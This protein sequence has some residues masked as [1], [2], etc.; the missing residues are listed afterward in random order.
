MNKKTIGY[1]LTGV[2]SVSLSAS[3]LPKYPSE[4]YKVNEIETEEELGKFY[5]YYNKGITYTATIVFALII[6]LSLSVLFLEKDSVVIDILLFVF[7]FV[8]IF[9][10]SISIKYNK[11]L[12][13]NKLMIY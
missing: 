8:E 7:I 9:R 10:F 13:D 2:G 4:F 12:R 3:K 1:F 6:L 5:Y 11:I